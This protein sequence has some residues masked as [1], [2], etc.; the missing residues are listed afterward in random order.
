MFYPPS[1]EVPCMSQTFLGSRDQTQGHWGT[2]GK[3][4][5][6]FECELYEAQLTQ[7]NQ[8]F[9]VILMLCRPRNY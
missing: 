1:Q 9:R 3:A 4:I 6:F 2:K 5:G 8:L 7:F